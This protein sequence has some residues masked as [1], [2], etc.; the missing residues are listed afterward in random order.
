MVVGTVLSAFPFSQ[1]DKGHS[2]LG[3]ANSGGCVRSAPE[4]FEK[5]Q[6]FLLHPSGDLLKDP[7][8]HTWRDGFHMV[9]TRRDKNGFFEK[10]RW[11]SNYS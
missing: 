4:H 11:F 8:T 2:T 5:G 3:R 10:C 6:A 1:S 9:L 7:G